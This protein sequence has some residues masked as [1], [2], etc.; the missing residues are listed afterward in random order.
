MGLNAQ[1]TVPAFTAGQVLT[2]AQQN[3]INTGIPVFANSTARDAAFGGTGEKVLAE[4]QYAFLEDTNATQF[5]D[6]AAW[7]TVGGGLTLV[8]SQTIGTTVGSVTVTDAFSAAYE[9]YRIIVSGGLASTTPNLSM[10][11]GATTTGYY[12]NS[13]YMLYNSTG[14]TGENGSNTSNFLRVA[15]GQPSGLQG[16]IE[17]QQPF[18]AARTSAQYVTTALGA[19][20]L[21]SQGGGF[22]D[23]ATSYTGFTLTPNSG[24]ITGGTI[25]VYGYQNS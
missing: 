6:G 21:F 15:T 19:A 20:Q 16:T 10:I 3:N 23:N 14:I 9:N 24:T 8:K 22:L 17:I 18:I 25:R 12:Y 2:A 13:F 4:G 5:Y 11:L 7:Q 1:T